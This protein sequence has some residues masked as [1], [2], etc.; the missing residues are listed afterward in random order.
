MFA[1][2]SHAFKVDFDHLQLSVLGYKI[3]CH[4][5]HARTNFEYRNVRTG[6]HRVGNGLS[7]G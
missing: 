6:I 7:R 3:L 2:V 4:H 1:K 5:P